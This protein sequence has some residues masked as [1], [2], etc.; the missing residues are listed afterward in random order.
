MSLQRLLSRIWDWSD[1]DQAGLPG[2][3]CRDAADGLGVSDASIAFI[4][5]EGQRRTLCASSD[6]AAE[7]DRWQFTFNE[8]PCLQ[9]AR[10]GETVEYGEDSSGEPP[11]PRLFSKAAELGFGA[12]AGVPLSIHAVT[13]GAM[14]L[15][16]RGPTFA[17]GAVADAAASAEAISRLVVLRLRHDIDPMASSPAQEDAVYRA[18]GVVSVQLGIDVEDALALLRATAW[19]TNRPLQAVADDVVEGLLR[20][21]NDAG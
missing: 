19:T 13:F 15:Q 20:F 16:S 3:L 2:S 12:I 9:A 6:D 18:T 4:G 11:W 1:T 17:T 14:N 10:T 8:G 5:A 7:L 21:D